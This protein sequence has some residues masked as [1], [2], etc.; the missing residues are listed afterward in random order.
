MCARDTTEPTDVEAEASRLGGSPPLRERLSRERWLHSLSVAE[1]AQRLAAAFG[2]SAA[3]RERAV[4]AGLL[5]DVAKDLPPD[6]VRELARAWADSGREAGS[7][8]AG[9]AS[10]PGPAFAPLLHAPAGARLAEVDFGIH[11]DDL[12]RAIAWHPTATA[13]MPAV[14]QILFVADYLEPRR[15]HL[16]AGDRALLESGLTGAAELSQ[17][18]CGVLRKKLA[19]ILSRGLPLHPASVAAWNVRCARRD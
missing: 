5:H 15:P 10:S 12:L 19:W 13:D 17:L 16:P 3:D 14:G 18:F 1:T 2:W 8:T 9:A 6:K 7:A 11:D 4:R